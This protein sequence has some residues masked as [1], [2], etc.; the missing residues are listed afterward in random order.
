MVVL[1]AT[2]I[3]SVQMVEWYAGAFVFGVSVALMSLHLNVNWRN[4]LFP[5]VLS[6]GGAGGGAGLYFLTLDPLAG[7]AGV[8]GWGLIALVLT[9]GLIPRGNREFV[10]IA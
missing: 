6:W 3:P 10:F 1:I 7:S 4:P 5:L 8:L 9:L 2:T